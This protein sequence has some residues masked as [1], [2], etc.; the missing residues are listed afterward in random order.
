MAKSYVKVSL[1]VAIFASL[2]IREQSPRTKWNVA[3]WQ[4]TR[5]EFH[6]EAGPFS[7]AW[8]QLTIARETSM[9]HATSI[10][11]REPTNPVQPA[12]VPTRERRRPSRSRASRVKRSGKAIC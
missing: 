5:S 3:A 2:R 8:L 4:P 12:L 9:S 6:G 7:P 1:T 10:S 11:R